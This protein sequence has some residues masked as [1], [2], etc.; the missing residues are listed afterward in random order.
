MEIKIKTF[1]GREHFQWS[2]GDTNQLFIFTWPEYMYADASIRK[3][4]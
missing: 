3:V 4:E 1:L 2:G